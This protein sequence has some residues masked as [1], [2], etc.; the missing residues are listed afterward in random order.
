[1]IEYYTRSVLQSF[2]RR[3]LELKKTDK[4]GLTERSPAKR[5]GT[6]RTVTFLDTVFGGSATLAGCCWVELLFCFVLFC[7]VL[8]CFD[9][10]AVADVVAAA[11]I[12]VTAA[13]II[14]ALF[15]TMFNFEFL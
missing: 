15:D 7:F 8:F 10:V 5:S 9:A 1:M 3:L 11:D 2:V 6:F 14:I 12:A 4:F 13:I